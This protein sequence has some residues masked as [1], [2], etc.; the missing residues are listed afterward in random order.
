MSAFKYNLMLA[1]LFQSSTRNTKKFILERLQVFFLLKFNDESR[2]IKLE[3]NQNFCNLNSLFFFFTLSDVVIT[4]RLKFSCILIYQFKDE[5]TFVIRILI[6][7]LLCIR[8]ILV[9]SFV[10]I[11]NNHLK[12]KKFSKT[13][14]L[15]ENFYHKRLVQAHIQQR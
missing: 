3:N 8:I 13:N 1:F 11:F 6:Y 2:T 9:K 14:K 7:L 4:K 10:K 5:N 12:A 15:S